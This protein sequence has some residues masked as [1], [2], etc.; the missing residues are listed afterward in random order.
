MWKR[1]LF[2]LLVPGIGAITIAPAWASGGGDEINPLAPSAW[3]QDLALWT[4]AVFVCLAAILWKFAWGPIVAALD[5]R[6]Q[7]IADDIAGAENANRKARELLELHQQKLDEVGEEVRAILEQ[8]RRDAEK[9]GR[10]LIEKA[11]KDAEHEQQRALQRI[12]LAADDALKELADRSA[13]LAVDLAGR[14]VQ[15]KINPKD[16]AR[17]IERAI[18][19]FGQQN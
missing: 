19:G 4:A 11:K 15:Q 1:A 8:G 6:E 14:I 9:L 17:L 18:A 5:K 10:V 12:E 16:H 2:F 7:K 3:K 13:E